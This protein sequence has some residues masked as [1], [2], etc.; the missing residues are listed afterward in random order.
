[1]FHWRL[2]HGPSWCVGE[3]DIDGIPEHR[4]P[5]SPAHYT[6][7][8]SSTPPGFL[9]LEHQEREKE[10]LSAIILAPAFPVSRVGLVGGRNRGFLFWN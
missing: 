5:V 2:E 6:L 9:A 8:L 10:A 1:M 7:S 3:R 4:P